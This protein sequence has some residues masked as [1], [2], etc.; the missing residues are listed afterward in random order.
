MGRDR[1]LSREE[2]EERRAAR[3]SGDELFEPAKNEA[4]TGNLFR[5]DDVPIVDKSISRYSFGRHVSKE[6][7]TMETPVLDTPGTSQKP[8]Q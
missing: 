4:T 6:A 7:E 5:P 2:K 3:R 1:R 8:L